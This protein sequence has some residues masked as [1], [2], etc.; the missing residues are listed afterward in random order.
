MTKRM[1][2]Q[3]RRVALALAIGAGAFAPAAAEA[4]ITR[5]SSSDA[6]QSLVF[7]IG[8][9]SVRGEDARVD[10]DVLLTDLESLAFDIKDFNGATFGAEYLF[11][12]GD[13]LEG[14]LGAA[15]ISEPRQASIG[16]SSTR[17]G[18]RSNRTSS[19]ASFR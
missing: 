19:C 8:Y 10:G 7:N 12:L 9:F 18:P 17:T 5:V 15:S 13:Y 6:R 1:W 16:T 14:G 4:Q 11:G 2:K 3:G